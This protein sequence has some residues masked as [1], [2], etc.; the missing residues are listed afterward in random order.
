M[1]RTAVIK[2]PIICLLMVLFGAVCAAYLIGDNI[3]ESAIVF[4]CTHNLLRHSQKIKQNNNGQAVFPLDFG[5]K[6]WQLH[7]CRQN[8]PRFFINLA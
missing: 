3:C 5:G 1:N 7:L 6:V 8:Q 4:I 2:S